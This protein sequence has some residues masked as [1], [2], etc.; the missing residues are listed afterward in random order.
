MDSL[1][2]TYSTA[3]ERLVRDEDDLIGLLAYAHYK[4]DKRDLA[5]SGT[6]G[7]DDLARHHLTLTD[8]LIQQYRDNALRR[9]EA[10]AEQVVSAAEPEI[11]ERTRTDAIEAN[12]NVILTELR[13]RTLWWQAILWNVLAWLI[14]LAITGLV[15]V[16]G[17]FL[18]LAP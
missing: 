2:Q 7:P 14:S 15:L 16:G 11:Q 12:A 3:F 6:V 8:R 1:S 10:Y 9:L 13:S 18:K 4:S 17:G 5:R